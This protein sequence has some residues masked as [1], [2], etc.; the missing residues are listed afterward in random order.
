MKT[1]LITAY[2]INPF[3]GSEDGTGWNMSREIAKKYKVIV[4]TRENNIPHVEKYKSETE[5]PVLE[6]MEFHGFDLPKWAMWWKKKIGER[7][8]VLYYY[9]W[10]FF[11]VGFIK[12]KQF[13]FDAAHTLNFHSDNTP[14][15]LWRLGKPTFWGPVGHHPKVE[16][17]YILPLYGWKVYLTDRFYFLLK[18]MLRNLDPFFRLA[19]RK[20]SKIFVINTS[21][22]HVMRA[23]LDKSIL[24]P[25][26]AS[27]EVVQ[28]ETSKDVFRVLS[29]GRFV[30]MK[31]FDLALESF[32]QFAEL[33]KEQQEQPVELVLVGKGEER[34]KLEAIAQKLKIEHLINWVKWVDRKEMEAIYRSSSVFLFP[35][36]EGAGMVVPEAMSYGLPVVTL[37]NYGPGELGGNAAV[38]VKFNNRADCVANLAF[39]LKSI[40]ENPLY[41]ETLGERS[42]NRYETYFKWEYKAEVITAAYEEVF[43]KKE[44][45]SVAIFHPSSELYGADRILV[46]AINAYPEN[47]KKVVYLKFQGPLINFIEKNTVNTEVKIRTG[48]PVIYRKIFTPIGILNFI[49]EYTAFLFF[50]RKENKKYKFKSAYVN[51][52]SC[53]FIL[54]VLYFFKIPRYIHVHEIIDSPKVIGYVTSFLS[55]TFAD[56]VIC[57][58]QA[59]L[60]GMRKYVS[61]LEKNSSVLHNGI[62]PVPAEMKVEGKE[63]NFYLFG[64]IMHKKGQWYLVEALSKIPVEELKGTRFILMG[65]ALQGNE[66]LLTELKDKINQYGLNEYVEIKDFAPNISDAMAEADVCLVPSLM[67]D[68]FPTTVLEAM[69]AGRPVIAT[70]HGGAKEAILD[71]ETGYLVGPNQPEK[72]A[73]KIRNFIT[74]K[75]SISLFGL[76]AKRRYDSGF[77]LDHFNT[78]WKDFIT[79]NRFV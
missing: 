8:Y 40:Y 25:A 61:S 1:I 37:D 21:V 73:E 54:P 32:A 45:K 11:I 46:N 18:W 60:E 2:A 22:S 16:R 26:V 44:E 79:V 55:K 14:T 66:H 69:S 75:H 39:S 71:N 63:L 17:T 62:S 5:D 33:I 7:G 28:K 64:R 67:K 3:K 53:S 51:T 13:Q 76:N 57:V 47:V 56:R 59:V 48:M 19:V 72:L 74:D 43:R 34:E 6:N 78:K 10:Q 58:S 23:P 15:F 68:P 50:L 77:T 35:S 42:R 65:G 20:T 9:L 49:K 29:V 41:A 4:I 36:H 30:Y 38:K 31:G 12:R 52:L 70:N 24:L 27:E